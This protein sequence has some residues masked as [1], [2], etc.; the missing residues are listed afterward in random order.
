MSSL[1]PHACPLCRHTP[2]SRNAQALPNLGFGQVSVGRWL[3][4]SVYPVSLGTW[5]T[6][7]VCPHTAFL[8]QLPCDSPWLFCDPGLWCPPTVPSR[9]HHHT[10]HHP[11]STVAAGAS[12]GLPGTSRLLAKWCSGVAAPWGGFSAGVSRMGR[13]QV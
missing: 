12:P 10:H 8:T 5:G 3:E 6:L 4:T 9:S 11:L 13:G 1:Q 2:D 7:S